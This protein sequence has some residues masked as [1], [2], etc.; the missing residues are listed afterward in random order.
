VCPRASANKARPP[1][2]SVA[3]RTLPAPPLPLIS[4]VRATAAPSFVSLQIASLY[5]G[6]NMDKYTR[7]KQ[8]RN[9][10]TGRSAEKCTWR[11]RKARVRI[12]SLTA[13]VAGILINNGIG[14]CVKFE[15]KLASFPKVRDVGFLERR[16][17]QSDIIH[18]HPGMLTVA[19]WQGRGN[20]KRPSLRYSC[21]E[22]ARGCCAIMKVPDS[23]RGRGA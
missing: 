4:S 9:R 14:S 15:E 16:R 10:G 17:R 11:L 7:R 3:L 12:V 2:P 8:K 18:W 6:R 23:T 1:L 20:G 13:P 21:C 5:L 19:H 22:D